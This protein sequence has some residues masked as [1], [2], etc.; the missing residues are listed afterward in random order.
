MNCHRQRFTERSLPKGDIVGKVMASL[1]PDT[2]IISKS[3]VDHVSCRNSFPTHERVASS[4]AS[5]HPAGLGWVGSHNSVA[6]LESPDK[7]ADLDCGTAEFVPQ[8]DG[9]SARPLAF[10]NV[11]VRAANCLSLNLTPSR[12]NAFEASA[13][14]VF[15]RNHDGSLQRNCHRHWHI[16]ITDSL[17]GCV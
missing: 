7:R 15:L 3:A 10:D 12:G 14:N 6:R 13:K 4:A 8:N 2:Q 11:N 5:T 1:G 16:L 9:R 17:D